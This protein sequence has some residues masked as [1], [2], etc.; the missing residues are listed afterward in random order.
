MIR[1]ANFE[2][3]GSTRYHVENVPPAR[4]LG[5]AYKFHNPLQYKVDTSQSAFSNCF[6]N[7]TENHR[8]MFVYNTLTDAN[9]Y[10]KIQNKL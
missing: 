1:L 7:L 3:P 4:V 8:I 5:K 6:H 9:A 10:E 2:S